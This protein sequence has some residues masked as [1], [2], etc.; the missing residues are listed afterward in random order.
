MSSLRASKRCSSRFMRN[1][2]G[3]AP[4]AVKSYCYFLLL[5]ILLNRLEIIRRNFQDSERKLAPQFALFFIN[6]NRSSKA[7][8]SQDLLETGLIFIL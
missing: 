2:V 4:D 3:K 6:R 1:G 5:H 7:L 8:I